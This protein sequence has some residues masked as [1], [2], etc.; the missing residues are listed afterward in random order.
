MNDES[1]RKRKYWLD[2]PTNVR[3][4]IWG[5]VTVCILVAAADLFYEKHVPY[6]FEHWFGFDGVFGFV[7]CVFLVLAAK[8][9]RKVLKRDED[10]YD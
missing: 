5:L 6:R 3:R 1:T 10:Y 4:I 7:S 9:L 2:D 8:Q